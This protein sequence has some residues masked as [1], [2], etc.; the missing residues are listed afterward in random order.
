MSRK[1]EPIEKNINGKTNTYVVTADQCA[2]GL[3][4]PSS[5][6]P[7]TMLPALKPTKFLTNSE[8][9]AAQLSRRCSK[10][11]VHQPLVGGRCK[12][13]AMY[14]SKLV[15]SILKGVALQAEADAQS[16]GCRDMITA[17]PVYTPQAEKADFGPPTH[18]SVPK[19]EKKGSVPITY[20]ETNFKSRYLDEYT[21]ETLAPHLIRPA[22][23][24]ELNYFNS[25]VWKLSTIEDMR[26]VPD[27]ILVRSR[28][29]LCNKGDAVKPDVRAR[30]VSCELNQGDRNDAF[31]ASTPPLEGKRILFSRYVSERRRIGRPL[32][33]SFVDVRK[34]YFNAIPERAMYIYIYIHI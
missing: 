9:M 27:H 1:E 24:D 6:D 7:E 11:H 12:N 10:D 25:K 21:G 22:I 2:Y 18:S 29:V 30:L 16:A 19:F 3:V 28:W 5:E 4:T 13:A 8:L 20:E 26:R 23:E 15:R 14:P 33:I 17:M 32:K 31:S 34:A